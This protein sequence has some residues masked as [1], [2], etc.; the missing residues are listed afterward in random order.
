MDHQEIEDIGTGEEQRSVSVVFD[1]F[2]KALV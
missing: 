1:C 2:Y